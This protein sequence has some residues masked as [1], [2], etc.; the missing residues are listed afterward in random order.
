MQKNLQDFKKLE[1]KIRGFKKCNNEN[2][3][4]KKIEN[5]YL[6]KKFSK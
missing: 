3:H 6:F 4:I 2:C 5:Q 1:T